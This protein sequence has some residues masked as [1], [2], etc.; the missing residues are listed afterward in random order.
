M[1]L[2]VDMD[3]RYPVPFLFKA[4]QAIVSVSQAPRQ[5]F[6][7]RGGVGWRSDTLCVVTNFSLRSCRDHGVSVKHST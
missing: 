4:T 2:A 3:D 6:T 5:G 7:R 1:V